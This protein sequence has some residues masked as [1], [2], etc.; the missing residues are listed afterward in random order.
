MSAYVLYFDSSDTGAPVMN[1]AVGSLIGVLDA[2]L[3]NGFN[4]KAV[5]SVN[6]ASGVA[7]ATINGHGYSSVA[8]KDVDI[9]GATPAALNG[10]KTITVLNANTISFAAPGVA[11][12]AATGTITAKRSALAWT[13][14]FTGTG[15]AIYKRSDVTAGVMMLR[16]DDSNVSPASATDARAFM[17]ESATNVDTF[18]GQAPTQ[19]QLADGQYWNKG[20]NN[21]TAKQWSLIGDSKGFYLTV[22]SNSTVLPN[23]TPNDSFSGAVCGMSDFKS[24]VVGDAYNTLLAGCDTAGGG[25]GTGGGVIGTALN[26]GQNSSNRTMVAARPY[27]QVGA[28]VQ[29]TSVGIGSNYIAS[30]PLFPSPV[31]NGLLV[32][33]TLLLTE[34]IASVAQ[35]RGLLR[36]AVQMLA[37]RVL[38]HGSIIDTVANLPGRKLLIWQVY[39]IGGSTR[40]ALDLTGPW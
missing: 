22:Q 16:V 6:V 2:C 35:V 4:N 21:A 32:N 29:L 34:Q 37:H 30:F 18:T 10:R 27:N 15:K 25:G 17:V 31:D 24:L 20:D 39:S 38:D 14:E 23:P 7:T 19:G 12:G 1:N 3:I 9:A 33:P 8:S 5:A 13:K 28:S 40:F 26:Y 36:G 11:D